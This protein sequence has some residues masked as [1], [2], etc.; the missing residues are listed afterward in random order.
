MTVADHEG[1]YGPP[2]AYTPRLWQEFQSRKGY[3]LRPLLPLLCVTPPMTGAAAQFAATIWTDFGPVH[4]S[5][6]RQVAD[7]CRRHK[8]LHGTSLYEEQMYIQAGQAGDMFRHWRAG[9]VVEIDALLE[10]ARMPLDFKEAVS[11][12]HFD[13]KPLVV[14][15]QG[16]QG[17]STYFS[18]EKA[19]L[20][21][22]MALLWGANLLVP[23]F[24][25]DQQK[26]TWPPQWF[27]RT[28]VLALLPPLCRLRESRSVHEWAGRHMSRRS[29]SII[30]LKRHSRIRQTL[31][32]TKPHRDLVWNNFMDQ[33]REFLLRRCDWNLRVRAGITMCLT[34]IFCAVRKFVATCCVWRMKSF[35]CSCCRP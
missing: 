25:Y 22:N 32:S 10:R 13:R 26:I 2:I 8:L 29:Q 1:S 21:T 15:N 20:G 34:A 18:L 31:L 9:S 4:D 11:V 12:A 6:T 30:R 33:T 23:Y 24:D 35:V 27:R 28:A 7:W 14:E 5:F 19:R 17:H 3:D 16:L